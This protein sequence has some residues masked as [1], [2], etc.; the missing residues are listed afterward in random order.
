M[1]LLGTRL[2][3]SQAYLNDTSVLAD[4]NM[5]THPHRVQKFLNRSEVVLHFLQLGATNPIGH[6]VLRAF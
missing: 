2:V 1:A 5:V 6:G 4:R 3:L